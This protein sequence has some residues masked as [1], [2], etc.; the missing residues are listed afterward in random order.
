MVSVMRCWD[1]KMGQ[2]SS[3]VNMYVFEPGVLRRR[4]YKVI[5]YREVAEELGAGREVLLEGISRQLAYYASRRLSKMLGEE[6]AY[7]PAEFDGR[8][9]G[10]KKLV[11]GYAFFLKK[12]E[13]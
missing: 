10:R 12:G 5:P 3:K 7:A 11:K 9:S 13:E 8:L 6:V 1:V 2:V 4:W